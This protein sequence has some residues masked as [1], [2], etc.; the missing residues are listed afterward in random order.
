MPDDKKIAVM[1]GTFDPIHYGHLAAAEAARATLGAGRAVFVPSGRPPHKDNMLITLS[2][3]RY[4][5]CELATAGNPA[6][7]VSKTEIERPGASYT[8][9][10]IREL[11]RSEPDGTEIY[12]ITGADSL[13][14][15][16]SWRDAEELVTLC[17]F[18]SATRPGYKNETFDMKIS[19][20]ITFIET[21]ALDI[22]SSDIRERVRKKWPVRYLLPEPVREY[23]DENNLYTPSDTSVAEINEYLKKEL[24]PK[25]YAHTLGVR[26]AAERL[27]ERYGEDRGRARLAAALHD[28]AKDFSDETTLCYLSRYNIPLDAV[29]ATQVNLAHPLVAAEIARE[30]FGINDI[31]VLEAIRSHTTG[32]ENMSRLEKIIYVADCIDESRDYYEGL[33]LIREVAYEDLDGATAAGLKAAINYTLNKKRPVHPLSYKALDFIMNKK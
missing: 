15:I 10:T 13:K 29:T 32:R 23:I 16:L 2:E 25:R 21:P 30:K 19:P 9:D 26:E 14:E 3:H 12:F 17:N 5:M 6:F 33:E 24:S 22:S 31:G 4:R 7:T 27:A 28:C 1:G 18:V 20:R 11:K 8:V